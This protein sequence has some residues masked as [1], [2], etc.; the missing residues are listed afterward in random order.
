MTVFLILWTVML[1]NDGTN[2][3][4]K[5]VENSQNICTALLGFS[6]KEGEGFITITDINDGIPYLVDSDAFQRWNE[7]GQHKF[8]FYTPETEQDITPKRL[9]TLMKTELAKRI[10][11]SIS[12]DVQAQSIG[13]V[14]GL[15]HELMNEGDTIRIKDTGFTPKLYLE[16]RISQT[17]KFFYFLR[18]SSTKHWTC[19]W[20]GSRVNE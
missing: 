11:S 4:M 14:F 6:K 8:G 3:G 10:N 1:S 13:R 15:A 7:R 18:C 19:I 12:Y 17:D 16:A 2:V 9:M 20:P 5:R